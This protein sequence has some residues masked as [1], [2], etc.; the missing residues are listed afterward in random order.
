MIKTILNKIGFLLLLATMISGCCKNR[1]Q[2]CIEADNLSWLEVNANKNYQFKN[3]AGNVV[4][5]KFEGL[6]KSVPTESE[7][8]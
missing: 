1:S 5:L 3:S 2:A 6:A 8:N 7:C 4:L